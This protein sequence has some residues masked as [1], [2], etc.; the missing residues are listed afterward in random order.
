MCA[1]N[2][3]EDTIKQYHPGHCCDKE[4]RVTRYRASGRTGHQ[5]EIVL[6]LWLPTTR[7][8]GARVRVFTPMQLG[9]ID[10]F[11]PQC[12]SL[13]SRYLVGIYT[14]FGVLAPHCF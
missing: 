8:E 6:V 3:V 1:E 12:L 9:N 2:H 4:D 14:L 5:L 11:F 13:D 10:P 7:N